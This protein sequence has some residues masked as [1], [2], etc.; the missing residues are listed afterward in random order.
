MKIG[1]PAG[2]ARNG[3]DRRSSLLNRAYRIAVQKVGNPCRY[4]RQQCFGWWHYHVD[5][6]VSRVSV[7]AFV[8]IAMTGLRAAEAGALAPRRMV[9][10]IRRDRLANSE[11][12]RA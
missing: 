2:A 11:P 5:E 8:Q 6:E 10:G 12:T 9:V 3:G 1:S 7:D 4:S